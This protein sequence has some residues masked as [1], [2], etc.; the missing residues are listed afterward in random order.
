M[1]KL[2]LL[3]LFTVVVWPLQAQ[4]I[5]SIFLS[6]P[7]DVL[8][9]MDASSKNLLL[10]NPN[11]TV[12]VEVASALNGKVKRLGISDDFIALETSSVGAL[13]LKLLPLINNSQIV[14]VVNTVCGKSCDSRI[15]FYTT[16]WSPLENTTALFP[17]LNADSFIKPDVDRTS[18]DF[19]NAS[20]ALDLPVIKLELNATDTAINAC[21]DIE[22]YLSEEDY[23]KIKPFLIDSPKVFNWDKSGFR[24][25]RIENTTSVIAGRIL[26]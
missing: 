13:Q 7:D 17:Q 15:R 20:V 23:E 1:K 10:A 21:L 9:G 2:S 24:E 11:D 6:A 25:L 16:D 19:R 26:Q 22:S 18:D 5:S 12:V 3:L 14:C 4:N 8:F